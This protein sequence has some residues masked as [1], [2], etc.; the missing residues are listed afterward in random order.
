MKFIKRSFLFFF[1]SL[2]AFIYAGDAARV[3]ILPGSFVRGVLM[4]GGDIPLSESGEGYPI[5]ILL[6]GFCQLPNGHSVDMDG[7]M[8][9]GW[10]EGD[11]VSERAK[12]RL[13]SISYI[14]MGQGYKTEVEG[15]V[16]DNQGNIG[17]KGTVVSKELEMVSKSTIASLL[18]SV[19]QILQNYD[20]INAA[21]SSAENYIMN[22]VSTP[23]SDLAEYYLGMAKEFTPH[24]HIANDQE[25]T[26]F[27]SGDTFEFFTTKFRTEDDVDTFFSEGE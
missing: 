15:F 22:N 11:L 6:K 19:A 3:Q 16:F 1:L 25:V 5:F 24:I 8:A 7:S 21:A 14:F 4:T 23:F 27:F 26:I 12:I 10:A 13:I 17:I 9:F 2:P 20:L 18:D